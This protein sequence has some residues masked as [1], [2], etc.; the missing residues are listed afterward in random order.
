[1]KK[2]HNY[3]LVIMYIGKNYHGWQKQPKHRTVQ[4]VLEE[5]LK[6]L[7]KEDIVLIGSGRT[8]AGVHALG[9][10]ANFK[11]IS[12]RKPEEIYRYLNAT[13]PRDISVKSVE[14]VPLSFHARFSAKGK[15]YIYR[16]YTKPDPFLH[17]FGW[18][19][20][21]KLDLKGMLEALEIVKKSKDLRSLSKKGEY[22]REDVE[23][24][25]LSMTYDG[26]IIE[27]QITASHFL[28]YMVRKIVGHVVQIGLGSLSIQ[29]FENIIEAKDPTKGL[30][31]APPEGLFLKEVYY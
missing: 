3:K 16:I 17:G 21:K 19:I 5:K 31:I 22:L 12:Y 6:V 26:K 1:M 11:T 2:N 23:I 30:F 27:I 18:Y 10:V 7:F 14:E 4:G 29:E 25:E 9:Q 20:S 15:T 8:D 13:L 28:R 24:R